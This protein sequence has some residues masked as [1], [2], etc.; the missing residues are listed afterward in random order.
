MTLR[1]CISFFRCNI[2]DVAVEMDRILRP[3]G[4]VLLQDT[5]EMINKLSPIFRSLHWSITLYQ[6]QFL[7]GTKGFWRPDEKIKI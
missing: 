3:G 1:S 6:E 4:Y 5:V 7:V 2:V